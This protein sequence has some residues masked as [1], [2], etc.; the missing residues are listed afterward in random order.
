MTSIVIALLYALMN[1]MLGWSIIR[2]FLSPK[3]NDRN[4]S[5]LPIF[6]TSFMLGQCIFVNFW[7]LLGLTGQF[8]PSVIISLL[9]CIFLAGLYLSKNL[10]EQLI[11]YSRRTYQEIIKLTLF[12]K[13]IL[14]VL[15]AVM[16]LYGMA[17]VSFPPM[18]DAEAFYMVLPKVMAAS[19]RLVP[20]NN[21]FTFSQIGFFGEMHHAALMSVISPQAAKCFVWL[22]GFA[23]V[24]LLLALCSKARMGLRGNIIALVMLFTSTT[25]T[26]YLYDGK[27]EIFATALGLAACFWALQTNKKAGL[28]PYLLTGLFCAFACVA[29]FS[30]I[31]VLLSAVLVIVVWNHWQNLFQ[32]K[33]LVLFSIIGL[34]FLIG[35]MPHLIKNAVLFNEPFAP[36]YF[37]KAQGSN[38]TE[39]TWYTKET[40]RHILLTYPIALTFGKYSLLGGNLSPLILLFVPLLLLVKREQWKLSK[41]L[42]QMTAA[43]V[44]CL[45]IWMICCPSVLCPRCILPTL[46]L[47]IPI[48]AW[49]AEKLFFFKDFRLLKAS[50]IS[51][52]IVCMYVSFATLVSPY[53]NKKLI[54]KFK[55]CVKSNYQDLK[56]ARVYPMKNTPAQELANGLDYVNLNAKLGGRVFVLGYYTYHLRS[57]LLQCLSTL[58]EFLFVYQN[59]EM[60]WDYLFNGGFQY[61]VVQD[62]TTFKVDNVPSWLAV[63]KVYEDTRTQVYRISSKDPSHTPQYT[64]RQNPYPAWE[65]V[66]LT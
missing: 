40:I 56:C 59:T 9:C 34:L 65:V 28:L 55:D 42:V 25:F 51:S 37:L 13:T 8:K 12:W 38:W 22:T 14:A 46:L 1:L 6:S 21:Y 20:L 26:F 3:N 36:F 15:F 53:P 30:Y 35:I 31:P 24:G 5:I 44:I 62:N 33:T 18:G 27:I 23:V 10:Y 7:L 60:P 47:F 39:Q 57:D 52:L 61:V 49:C 41:P 11:I 4:F 29:K 17:A 64:T 54:S 45:I 43:A 50:V 32:L 66:S 16:C 19:Y 63:S 48:S 2:L 58:E